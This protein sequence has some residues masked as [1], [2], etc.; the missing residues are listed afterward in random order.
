[1]FGAIEEL[2]P[3]SF[4]ELWPEDERAQVQLI[5]VREPAELAIATLTDAVHIPMLQ[6]PRRLGELD[7][8]RPVVV[9]CH[10]GGRSRQV[11][12][13]LLAN[14]FERVYNLAGGIDAWSTDVDPAVPR[15]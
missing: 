11:A 7:P 1:M 2:S 6:I 12:A 4:C 9:M 14:G 13:F 5:D 3:R 8:Q 15:Y 10:S